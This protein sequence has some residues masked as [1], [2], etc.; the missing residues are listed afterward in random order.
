M[1]KLSE[2]NKI[3]DR[4]AV[5]SGK[6]GVGKSTIV[7]NLALAYAG[8]GLR[9]A[10]LDV[11][12][13]GPS[14]PALFGLMDICPEIKIMEGKKVFVPIEKFG[15]KMLSISFF[16]IADQ[17][18]IE[19]ESEGAGFLSQLFFHGLW[20]EIDVMLIDMP[21]GDGALPFKLCSQIKPNKSIIVT[22]PQQ[23]AADEALKVGLMLRNESLNVPILGVVE[24]MSWYSPVN[25]PDEKY[26]IFGQGGGQSLA[27][28]LGVKLITQIPLAQGLAK[29]AD[30]GKLLTYAQNGMAIPIFHKLAFD[31]IEN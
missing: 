31:L 17:K 30:E 24:N 18:L 5:T 8:Q 25:Y 27:N 14:V 13:F 4:I 7:A 6:N 21:P 9:T 20:D 3:E 11:D 26:E 28:T 10:I 23:L 29:S 19:E 15:V 22:T 12:P 2:F 1:E 16:S